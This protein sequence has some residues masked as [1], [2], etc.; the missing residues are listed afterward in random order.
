MTWLEVD[1]KWPA[2][3]ITRHPTMEINRMYTLSLRDSGAVIGSIEEADLQL[4]VEQLEEERSEDTDY[5]V[6]PETID[7]LQDRGASAGL[8]ALLRTAV[9]DSEGV[10]VSWKRA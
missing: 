1:G 5:Y 3:G 6:S 9:G 2:L 8:L 4:L 7:F 10:E